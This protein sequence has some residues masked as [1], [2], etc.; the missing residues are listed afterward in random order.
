MKKK[1]LTYVL[2]LSDEQKVKLFNIWEDDR[3]AL[4]C[5]CLFDLNKPEDCIPLSKKCGLFV[6]KQLKNN[7]K[8]CLYGSNF[9]LPIGISNLDGIILS[10][11]D[12]IYERIIKNPE[13]YQI[14][15]DV[16]KEQDIYRVQISYCG[17][18]VQE[19]LA[20][21]ETDAYSI[22]VKKAESLP[23]DEFLEKISI[24]EDE[25]YAY[26]DNE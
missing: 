9:I 11:W 4:E 3:L 16:I 12:D 20:N 1:V 22:A 17:C 13:M 2:N 24:Q 15:L 5:E 7:Y 23:N 10:V 26:I 14:D 19:V 18:Y 8:Y 25:W 21:A 6:V